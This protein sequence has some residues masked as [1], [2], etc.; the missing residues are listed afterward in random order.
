VH[1]AELSPP[2]RTFLRDARA[3]QAP[4]PPPQTSQS[5]PLRNPRSYNLSPDS[6][7]GPPPPAAGGNPPAGPPQG[8]E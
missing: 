5:P 3:A 1:R 7:D 8:N 4:Q 6:A 2:C